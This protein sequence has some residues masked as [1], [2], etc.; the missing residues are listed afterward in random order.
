MAF[1]MLDS[2]ADGRLEPPE[3]AQK[4]EMLERLLRQSERQPID[5]QQWDRMGR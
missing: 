4:I 3:I 2:N 1:R 5:L